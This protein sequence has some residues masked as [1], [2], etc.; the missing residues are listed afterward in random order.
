[1]TDDHEPTGERFDPR[2]MGGDLIDAE[3]QARYRLALPLVRGRRVLDA[4]CGVGWGS[5]L[6]VE[7][8][9]A[10]VVG[11]DIAPTAVRASRDLCPLGRFLVGDVAQLPFAEDSVDVV[12]CLETLEHTRQP[13]RALDEMRRV[14][15]PDGHLV[16]SSPNPAVYPAGNPFHVHELPPGEL[17]TEVQSRF[18]SSQLLRQH[19]MVS[20]LV[21]PDDAPSADDLHVK[22]RLVAPLGPGHDP[23][24]VVITASGASEL[25]RGVL[26]LAPSHQLDTLSTQ[27]SALQEEREAL[28][29]EH[30][31]IASE[32][33]RLLNEL[34]EATERA[35]VA[36]QSLDDAHMQLGQADSALHDL[37]NRL[38]KAL[39]AIE[40]ERATAQRAVAEANARAKSS[41][42]AARHA[43]A[44]AAETNV[45]AQRTDEAA[46]QLAADVDLLRAQLTGVRAERD[47]AMVDLVRAEQA[48]ANL[49]VEKD[50]RKADQD[51]VRE[52]TER[53]HI[54]AAQ[55]DLAEDE[56]DRLRA[57]VSWRVTGP[58][59]RARR[60]AVGRRLR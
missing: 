47:R 3:H 35:D 38:D 11:V 28:L 9:A 13:G 1:M 7:A 30:A 8:G 10:E 54:L 40:D 22:A 43:E 45:R 5:Q 44:M 29:G 52:L 31:R 6:M 21:Y 39:R 27:S 56:L 25:V 41:Q 57:T 48:T 12:I 58:L 50:H 34:S 2:Y 49:N 24:S 60:S 59:R 14:L 17:L 53:V 55:A 51:A 23:Y 20:S 37:T 4:G 26:M 16:V 46:R 18:G 15:R 36:N 42:D 33:E 19:L 32:R